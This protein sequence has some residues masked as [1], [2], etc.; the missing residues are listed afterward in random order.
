MSDVMAKPG[1]A[2]K[3][4]AR[5]RGQSNRDLVG[6]VTFKPQRQPAKPPGKPLRVVSEYEPAGD[7][8]TAIRDLWAGVQAPER[9]QV[10]LGV[11]GS[12]KT[13][14]MA[15]VIELRAEGRRWF[16]RPIK[17]LAAQLYGEMKQ[18]FPRQR[19]RVLRQLLRLLSAGSLRSP[20]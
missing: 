6:T 20:H 2:A 3:P 19:C 8:P 4:A 15:K 10:L 17:R 14:T 9:D 18:L 1:K 5:T 11:T 16:W 12:G 13:F 7:Q